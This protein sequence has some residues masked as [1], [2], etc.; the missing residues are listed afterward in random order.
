MKP[1]NALALGAVGV[2][3]VLV[4]TRKRSRLLHIEFQFD[5]EEAGERTF[6]VLDGHGKVERMINFDGQRA[7][8]IYIPNKDRPRQWELALPDGAHV[9]SEQRITTWPE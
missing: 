4:L 7:Q 6:T 2:G 8:V 3:V 1:W 5:S 9:L